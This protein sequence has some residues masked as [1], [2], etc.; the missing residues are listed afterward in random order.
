MYFG[1]GPLALDEWLLPIGG[2][3]IYLTIREAYKQILK[4]YKNT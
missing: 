2:G 3:L 4:R 1:F